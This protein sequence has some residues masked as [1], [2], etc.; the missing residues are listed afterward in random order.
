MSGATTG[1]KLH[2]S[3]MPSLRMKKE[4][5]KMTT[6]TSRKLLIIAMIMSARNLLMAADTTAHSL[7]RKLIRVVLHG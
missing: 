3:I 4:M 5:M 1:M 2:K 7:L 6:P